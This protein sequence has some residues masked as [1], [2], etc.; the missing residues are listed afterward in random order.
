MVHPGLQLGCRA[1]LRKAGV[2]SAGLFSNAGRVLAH[3]K[4]YVYFLRMYLPWLWPFFGVDPPFSGA[5]N[6]PPHSAMLPI[7]PAEELKMP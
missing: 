1:T 6:V 2:F 5:R 3:A 4:V 7:S